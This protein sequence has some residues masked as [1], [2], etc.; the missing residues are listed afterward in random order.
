MLVFMILF[1]V[2][3]DYSIFFIVILTHIVVE[4][5]QSCVYTPYP[6]WV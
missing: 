4:L 2:V 3:S 6:S 5:L 1:Q